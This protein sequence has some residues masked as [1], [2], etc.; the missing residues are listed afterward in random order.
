VD[1]TPELAEG[2]AMLQKIGER[3]RLS[4]LAAVQARLLYSQGRYD[5][6]E[7]YATLSAG[8]AANDDAGS[9]VFMRATRA[10]LEARGGN[11]RLAEELSTSAVAI[12]AKTDSLV[13]HA[14]ALRDRAE[15][16][17]ILGRDAEAINELRYAITLYERKNADGLAAATQSLVEGLTPARLG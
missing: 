12:A 6:S 11:A 15:V 9:Q 8:A 5:E 2:C 1:V 4:T 10:M 7:E 17:T 13:M 3:S 14:D 16:L